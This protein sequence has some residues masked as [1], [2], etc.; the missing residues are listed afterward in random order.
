MP[1]FMSTLGLHLCKAHLWVHFHSRIRQFVKRK[2]R[3]KKQKRV[4][5][6][7]RL[8][9]CKRAASAQS[10]KKRKHVFCFSIKKQVPGL[11]SG[12]LNLSTILKP[13][14]LAY[15]GKWA[16]SER[17][18]FEASDAEYLILGRRLHFIYIINM[19]YL[20]S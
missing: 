11:Q 14:T 18:R 2:Y 20:I 1:R 16:C 4:E 15:Y 9:P 10:F 8:N 7:Y 12:N 17:A 3:P 13:E 19:Q 5:S 6:F